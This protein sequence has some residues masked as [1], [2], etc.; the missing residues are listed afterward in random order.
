MTKK[1]SAV[2]VWEAPGKNRLGLLRKRLTAFFQ[3]KGHAR[4]DAEDLT[5]DVFTR[6]AK[7]ETSDEA[8][9]EGYIF[10]I[11][12]NLHVDRLRRLQVREKYSAPSDHE[13]NTFLNEGCD[14][15]GPERVLVSKEEVARVIEVL[16]QLSERTRE[17][18]LLH[19]MEGMSQR[20]IAEKL[21]LSV[22]AVEK[23]VAKAMLHIVKKAGRES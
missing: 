4:C 21:G 14:E 9:Q 23:N 20:E 17:I 15:L 12:R 11:A 6:L 18:F 8:R 5:Q 13:L 2:T 3:R 16:G 7:P 19:R 10:T 1:I 22:S